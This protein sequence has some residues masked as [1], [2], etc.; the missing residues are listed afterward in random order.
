MEGDTLLNADDFFRLTTL[1]HVSGLGRS[2]VTRQ[3]VPLGAIILQ[4]QPLLRYQLRPQCRSSASPFFT[5]DVWTALEHCISES[6]RHEL[7]PGVPTT[8]LAYLSLTPKQKDSLDDFYSP[9]SAWFDHPTYAAIVKAADVAVESIALFAHER[10]DDLAHFCLKIYSNAH[11][12]SSADGERSECHKKRKKRRRLYAQKHPRQHVHLAPTGS[13]RVSRDQLYISLF[14]W[15]SKLAHSCCPNTFVVYDPLKRVLTY[16]AARDLEE[17]EVVTFSYLPETI[18]A[19][20]G[21]HCGGPKDRDAI[22]WAFKFFHCA[23]ERCAFERSVDDGR[24]D[25]KGVVLKLAGRVMRSDSDAETAGVLRAREG[26]LVRLV[27]KSDRTGWIHWQARRLLALY[28]LHYFPRYFGLGLAQTLGLREKGWANAVE[29]ISILSDLVVARRLSAA[30]LLAALDS[31][32]LCWL[33]ADISTNR[34][35]LTSTERDLAVL[36]LAKLQVLEAEVNT[37]QL[38]YCFTSDLCPHSAKLHRILNR[39]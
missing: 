35:P 22:L 30:P 3:S 38:T 20:G 36:M 14:S 13:R 28:Y 8:F 33:A 12:L 7:C 23:C 9:D 19:A 31:G 6:A 17:G 27:H 34:I 2:L 15:A 39:T 11:S 4:E 16:R 37:P 1:Q 25:P 21:L 32:L 29:V 26:E 10:A 5:R 24:D 18:G